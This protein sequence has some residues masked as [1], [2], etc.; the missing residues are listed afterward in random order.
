MP[1]SGTIAIIDNNPGGAEGRRL[2]INMDNGQ[3]IDMIHG[4]WIYGSVGDH[5]EKGQFGVFFSGASGYG[6]E[7]YY[8]PHLH[9]TLRA[10][11]GLPFSNT[12]DF[13]LY[14]E[15]EEQPKDEEDEDMV[16]GYYAKGDISTTVY[17]IDGTSGYRRPVVA[18]ELDA[19]T[20]FNQAT[21]GKYGTGH[22]A[23]MA[24]ST[25][26]AIPVMSNPEVNTASV[27]R[28]WAVAVSV[29]I[30]AVVQILALF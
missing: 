10:N 9:L 15:K 22:V 8:G 28:N 3:V 5:V 16:N 18:G 30:I 24:Q 4:S 26:D 23:V 19:A 21:G 20:Q 13:E 6:S 29:V 12:L 25:F 17:W 14:I 11:R 1:D 7:F 27:V 2:E